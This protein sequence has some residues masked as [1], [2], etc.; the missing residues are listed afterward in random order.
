M[1][2]RFTARFNMVLLP[3]ERAMLQAIAEERGLKESD[4]VRQGIRREY[5]ELFGKKQPGKPEPKYNSDAARAAKAKS[6]RK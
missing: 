3:D 6:K 5:A 1:D 2:K 4:I